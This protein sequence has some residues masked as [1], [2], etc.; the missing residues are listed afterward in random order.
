MACVNCYNNCGG[1]PT[2][3]KCVQYTG[4]DIE[5]LGIE[6]G[7]S[8]A[9]LLAALQE[10]LKTTADGST[11]EFPELELCE[12]ITTALG[13]NEPTLDNIVQA[14]SNVICAIEEDV[15]TLD[16][17]VD[18]PLSISAPCLTL[19]TNPTRDQV[20]QAMA[21]KLCS[22]NTTVTSISTNY[23]T[24]STLCSLVQD[25]VTESPTSTQ[26]NS[27]MPK[28]V[29]LPY[30]GPLN[31][32]DSQGRGIASLGYD[33][34]Y[35]CNGQ[36]VGTFVT[37]DYRGRSPIGVNQNLPGGTLD[38]STDPA[39]A[40][41]NG[42]NFVAGTKKGSY[43]HQL[44]I[45]EEPT[46]SHGVVDPGHKHTEI[47][48]GNVSNHPGG[49]AGYDRPNGVQTNQ[50]SSATTGISI[51]S[52]GGGQPHNNTHPVIGAVFIMYIP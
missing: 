19:P 46:H 1:N 22:I 30:H 52:T 29:A 50:T 23:V 41:N 15:A 6:K 13:E 40:A 28:Y 37:P 51:S 10:K 4:P 8:L 49:S 11:I 24:T 31:V 26:Q 9:M 45:T 39:L 20:L 42:Y 36:T 14:I 38:S 18:P 47:G 35:M 43:T 33:K 2:S 44:S 7:D 12:S 32:F 27:T 48:P 34:V 5:F 16:G 21:T 25:C 3:D 17:D